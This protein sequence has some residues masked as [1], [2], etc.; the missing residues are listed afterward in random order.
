[1]FFPGNL[2]TSA[3][4]SAFSTKHLTDVLTKLN[5]TTTNNDR[6]KLKQPKKKNI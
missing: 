4:H 1:M 6:K 3:E 2:S 5:T